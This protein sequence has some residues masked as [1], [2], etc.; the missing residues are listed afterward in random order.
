MHGRV[1][2]PLLAAA[3]AFGQTIS[4][5]AGNG[6][7]GYSGDGGPATQAEI[8]RVVGLAVDA[9]GNVYLADQDNNRVRKVDTHGV[10]T[11]LAGTGVAGFSGD[12][13]VSYTHLDVYKR[14]RDGRRVRTLCADRR[15]ADSRRL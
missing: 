15:G 14:Q 8:N 10:I 11:T 3:I 13:P 6:T 2:L 4:T 9:A 7:A 12:G 1:L 5:F